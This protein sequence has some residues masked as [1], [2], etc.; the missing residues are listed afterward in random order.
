MILNRTV[1]ATIIIFLTTINA[2]ANPDT[3]D[4]LSIPDGANI[5]DTDVFSMGI[6][7]DLDKAGCAA[8]KPELRT[9]LQTRFQGMSRQISL[10]HAADAMALLCSVTRLEQDS[11]RLA[12]EIV[13]LE[14]SVTIL[15]NSEVRLNRVVGTL[16]SLAES[17][18][19]TD[20]LVHL[21]DIDTARGDIR[22]NI[23]DASINRADILA[24]R[25]TIS[26]HGREIERLKAVFSSARQL[27]IQ[28]D[29]SIVATL[30]PKAQ[31]EWLER[32]IGRVPT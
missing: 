30:D 23:I 31:Q 8:L 32:L 25:Q 24:I 11:T 5:W 13:R 29:P 4:L 6:A 16:Q 1:I 22:Q 15:E 20:R 21:T 27:A 18:T 3:P 12:N 26:N 28:E 9:A 10:Q 17:A 14:R 7:T 2:S 19:A